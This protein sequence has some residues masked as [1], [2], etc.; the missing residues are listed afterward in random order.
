MD[1]DCGSGKAEAA[2]LWLNLQPLAA[3]LNDVVVADDTLVSEAADAIEILR[4]RAPGLLWVA[5]ST[6]EAAVVVSEE[7][8]EDA[9]GRVKI[10]CLNQAEFAGE[11]V[12]QHA[13]ETLDA[14]FGLRAL[15][16]DEGDAELFQRATE[17]SGLALTGELFVDGPVMVVAS[18]DPAAIAVEGDGDALAAQEALEQAKVALGGF[19]GEELGGQ[20]FAGSI[21]LHTQS[22]EQG[23]ATFQPVVG[24]AVELDQFAFARGAQTTLAMG[25]RSA[26]AWRAQAFPTE[27]SAQG[28]AA[29]REAFSFDELVVKV[30]VVEA[31]V[32]CACQSED[33]DARALR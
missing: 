26:L 14:A 31:S 4:S 12:L 20:D 25:G 27:Q 21:V 29:Q 6:H 3:P 2:G 15:C 8:S 32:A 13:P 9:V 24:R 7:A 10:A 18:E 16:G 17:L 30:M 19:R 5:G 33:A 11:T 28:F 23:A 1:L 22:G